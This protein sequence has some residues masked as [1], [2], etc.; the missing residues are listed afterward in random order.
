MLFSVVCSI[1]SKGINEDLYI[2]L[3]S[4]KIGHETKE[5]YI[6]THI[7]TALFIVNPNHSFYSFYLDLT[8]I[9]HYYLSLDIFSGS[10]RCLSDVFYL[11]DV[12]RDQSKVLRL[13]TKIRFQVLIVCFQ[14]KMKQKQLNDLLVIIL[15]LFNLYLHEKECLVMLRF[16]QSRCTWPYQRALL[17]IS[18]F[19]YRHSLIS[20][21]YNVKCLLWCCERLSV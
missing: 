14:N 17:D 20:L 1:F 7:C 4:F 9:K 19:F 12:F 5:A 3:I 18:I 2:Y 6:F 11:L 10:L 15:F 21:I 16:A 8:Q 13:L